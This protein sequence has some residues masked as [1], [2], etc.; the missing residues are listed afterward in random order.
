VEVVAVA[1]EMQRFAEEQRDEVWDRLQ[2]IRGDLR[3]AQDEISGLRVQMETGED[4]RA[5][6]AEEVE[7]QHRKVVRGQVFRAKHPWL[8]SHAERARRGCGRWRKLVKDGLSF[9]C[10]LIGEHNYGVARCLIGGADEREVRRWKVEDLHGLSLHGRG[11][12]GSGARMG[13]ITA[14]VKRI[15]DQEAKGL[16]G[17]RV[18]RAH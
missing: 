15:S 13:Q 3:A 4:N 8:A 10:F 12:D 14:L 2:A 18:C 5:G 9:L 7:A 6:E 11:L 17:R 16:G 1:C